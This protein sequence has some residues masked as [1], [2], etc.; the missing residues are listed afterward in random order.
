MRTAVLN[1]SVVRGTGDC[2]S[3]AATATSEQDVYPALQHDA[4]GH[5]SCDA[6]VGP[7]HDAIDRD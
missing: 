2:W 6:Q 5:R 3:R 1:T 4:Q 7:P